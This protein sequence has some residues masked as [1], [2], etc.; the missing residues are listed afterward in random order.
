MLSKYAM[1]SGEDVYNIAVFNTREDAIRI[2]RAI[3]GEDA[4]AINVDYIDIRMGAKY[5]DGF[6]YNVNEDG[7]EER[8]EIIPTE[9]QEIA[10]L[11]AENQ[12]LTL[13]LADMIGG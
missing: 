9:K 5:R 12:Q 2:S 7:T 10:A 3:K 1:I 11:K 8:A 13:A 6:F 4:T